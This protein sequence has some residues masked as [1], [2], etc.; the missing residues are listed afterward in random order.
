MD[1]FR[2][3]P[4]DLSKRQIRLICIENSND[5]SAAI[6]VF[7][8][9]FNLSI[10]PRYIALS[11]TWGPPSPVYDIQVQ[12][13]DGTLALLSIRENLYQFLLMMRT[14]QFRA[15][16]TWQWFFIDQICIDQENTLERNHQVNQMGQ[17]YLKA[18]KA[19]AW[20]GPSFPGSDE[21]M[22]LISSYPN[23]SKDE[24]SAELYA[25]M[26][27]LI[28]ANEDLIPRFQGLPYWS[29]LWITQEVLIP[30]TVLVFLGRESFL[31]STKFGYWIEDVQRILGSSTSIGYS[32][33]LCALARIRKFAS[34]YEQL[35][36]TYAISLIEGSECSELK[37]KFF[38]LMALIEPKQKIDIDYAAEISTLFEQVIRLVVKDDFEE[39]CFFDDTGRHE[40]RVIARVHK[41]CGALNLDRIVPCT[42]FAQE[43]FHEMK[44]S[45]R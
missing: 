3:Q 10:K 20:L 2:H 36:W 28:R 7:V 39:G 9:N 29:R 26:A 13:P 42:A 14:R 25:S 6:K 5:E 23:Y 18:V 34:T 11:Y 4:L 16:E 41:I 21:L 1:R 45:W 19:V 33:R 27:K 12:T 32:G 44:T 40:E 22:A 37:D 31:W 35:Q 8:K 17:I 15:P 24:R 38:G 43:L 30:N